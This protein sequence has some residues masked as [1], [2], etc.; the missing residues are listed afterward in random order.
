MGLG[1]VGSD[2]ALFNFLCKDQI[3]APH[4]VLLLLLPF[5]WP[6]IKQ[7]WILINNHLKIYTKFNY[8]FGWCWLYV[9]TYIQNSFFSTSIKY[10]L[11]I[12]NLTCLKMFFK[13]IRLNLEHIFVI[14]SFIIYIHIYVFSLYIFINREYH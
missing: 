11:N 8:T 4:C 12:W 9:Y 10:F 3:L 6:L 5:Q 13:H 2:H 14:N 1:R 7:V